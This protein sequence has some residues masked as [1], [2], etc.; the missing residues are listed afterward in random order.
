M[1]DFLT[2]S[3]DVGYEKP[4]KEVFI[5]AEEEARQVVLTDGGGGEGEW[6]KVHVG[7]DLKKDVE[8]AEGAGWK[9]V[10]WDDGP[11]A[12]SGLREYLDSM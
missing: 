5:A 6:T 11:T 2:L 12:D 4:E 8:A 10:W 7:D 1:I 9:G 3:Y